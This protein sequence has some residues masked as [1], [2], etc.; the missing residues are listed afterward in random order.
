M[1]L[2]FSLSSIYASLWKFSF[3]IYLFNLSS[4]FFFFLIFE[5]FTTIWHFFRQLIIFQEMFTIKGEVKKIKIKKITKV[6]LGMI[7]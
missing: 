3:F 5:Q 2:L 4:S 6:Y 7:F 1:I